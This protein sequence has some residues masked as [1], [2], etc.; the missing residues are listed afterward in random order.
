MQIQ[1]IRHGEYD[2]TKYNS[3]VHYATNGSIYGYDWFL[4]STA[5]DWDLLVEGD[6][7]VSVLPLPRAKN[8]W[9][10]L[11]L[12]Q[13]PL[14]PE[15][16]LYSVKPLSKKRVSAF[17]EA[18]P[19][20]FKVG[21]LTMEPLSIDKNSRFKLQQ[22]SGTK[23]DLSQPYQD[24]IDDFPSDY[25][26]ELGLAEKADLIP[27]GTLKPERL[28]AMYR[29]QHGRTREAEFAF[30]AI[31]RLMYQCLHRGWGSAYGVQNRDG[32]V[33][34]ATFIAYSHGRLFPLFQ[35]ERP[36]G[37]EAGALT[38]LWDMVIHSHAERP[39]RI[40]REEIFN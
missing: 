6:P 19:P 24:I 40:K 12:R 7:Y 29:E 1:L 34:A 22:A 23:L 31:Q 17:W 18:V 10:R 25:L 38:L 20:E 14:V 15:L 26:R 30:H 16:A 11:E 2:K 37:K 36:A 9:G 28:A 35:L 32:E 21:K 13:P 5:R 3:C 8:W 27:T 33:L 39:L 4:N